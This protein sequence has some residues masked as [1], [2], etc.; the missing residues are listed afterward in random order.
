[1][2]EKVT[3]NVQGPLEVKNVLG[4]DGTLYGGATVY[5]KLDLTGTCHGD[6]TVLLDGQAD[7]N[8]VVHGDVH[9][10]GGKLRLRGIIDG[11]LGVKP[12]ADVLV[13]VGTVLNGQ[14]LEADGT[15]TGM[16]PGS[17]FKIADDAQMMRPQADG[18]WTPSD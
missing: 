4:I 1:M 3:G 18:K 9:A 12:G 15:F 17:Q 6:I 13:A 14:R 11:R 7:I 16:K 5:G 10:R 2:F 8:A